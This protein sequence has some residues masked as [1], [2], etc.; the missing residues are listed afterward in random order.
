MFATVFIPT[1]NRANSLKRVLESLTKQTYKDFEVVIVDYQSTDKTPYVIDSFNKKLKIRC[2]DQ[3]AKGLAKAAN[4]AL[5]TART[6]IFIRTDDDVVMSPGWMAALHKTFTSDKKVGGVTG[7]TIIPKSARKNR[8]LFVTEERFRN[9]P[10][11]WRLIGRLY[12]DF[13]TEGQSHRVSHWFDSGAFS[14]GTNFDEALN[15]P[16]QEVTNLEACNM[17]VRTNLLKKIGGFDEAYGGVGDYHEPDA[18]F[19][20]KNLGYKLIFNPKVFLNHLPSQDGMYHERP[21]S[22][23]RMENFVL[24]YLR[25]IKPNSFRKIIR[26]L[27]YT[28]FLNCY[29][30]YTAVQLRQPKQ[31]G[32]LPG[33]VAGIIKYIATT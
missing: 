8:D 12:R 33:S 20:I 28:G 26:F 25:H 10:P 27:L 30:I 2:I 7:P 21:A 13:F 4:L 5:K 11:H 15:E 3:E 19:K 31:L 29:Y 16:L 1:G 14:L 17:A 18:A 9:G 22:F 6:E 23:S 24:F 32:A